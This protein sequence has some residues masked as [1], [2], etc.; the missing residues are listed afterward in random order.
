MKQILQKNKR[1]FSEVK[2][3]V[4]FVQGSGEGRGEVKLHKLR[5]TALG[6]FL[7]KLKT[8]YSDI[9]YYI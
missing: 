5:I 9:L 8:S 4:G 6:E 3:Q 7:N 2:G 1:I